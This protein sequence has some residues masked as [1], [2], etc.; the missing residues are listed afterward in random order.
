[1]MYEGQARKNT[2]FDLFGVSLGVTAT[3]AVK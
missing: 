1:M 2:I 3:G